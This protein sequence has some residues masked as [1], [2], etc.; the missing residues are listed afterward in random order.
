[1]AATTPLR[2]CQV[3]EAAL[4]PASPGWPRDTGAGRTRASWGAVVAGPPPDSPAGVP[5]PRKAPE[6]TP[7]RPT[8]ERSVAGG[9]APRRPQILLNSVAQQ[10]RSP[11]EGRPGAER[12]CLGPAA[13]GSR[14]GG[15]R[16]PAR[17][18]TWRGCR[19]CSGSKG[20]GLCP[21]QDAWA[22]NAVQSFEIWRC[23]LMSD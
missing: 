4:G 15:A 17:T 13:E 16:G 21:W 12:C 22:A 8:T 20:S 3:L 6:D 1:M 19:L 18:V 10:P 7:V 5:G 2:D 11:R 23:S 14:G 9:P